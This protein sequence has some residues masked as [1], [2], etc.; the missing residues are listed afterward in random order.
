MNNIFTISHHGQEVAKIIRHSHKVKDLEF[1]TDDLNPLQ[2]GMHNKSKGTSLTPHIHLSDTKVITEVQEVLYIV[3]GKVKVTYYTIDGDMI[4]SVVLSRG[5]ILIHYRM[6]H[7]FE[8]LE[9][10]QIFEIK[11]GP[12]PGTQH[13]KI[14]LKNENAN[15]SK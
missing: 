8:I 15:S 1:F 6:G 2:V 13:A 4:D 5:D 3:S 10:A 11:Q 7:G 14:Y 12:Y 9:D